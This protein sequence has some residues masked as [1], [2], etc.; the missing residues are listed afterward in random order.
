MG[1]SKVAIPSRH[2]PGQ[3]VYDIHPL[4]SIDKAI[5]E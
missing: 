2:R 4:D 1:R 5:L 3:G